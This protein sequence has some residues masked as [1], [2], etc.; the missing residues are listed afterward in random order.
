MHRTSARVRVLPTPLKRRLDITAEAARPA[1]LQRQRRAASPLAWAAA[2]IPIACLGL[3]ETAV[4][5]CPDG[6]PPPCAA[7]ARPAAR[8]SARAPDPNRIAVLPFRVTTADTLLGE[9]FAELLAT[10]FTGEGSPRAVD[11]AT[12][13]SAWRLNW[14]RGGVSRWRGRFP[15]RE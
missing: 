15:P 9:G 4:A 6:T 14:R 3:A 10:E 8:E 1:S 2:C 12:V 11:M 13:L 7:A 5:Q